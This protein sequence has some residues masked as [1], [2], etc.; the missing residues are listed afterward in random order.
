M[1]KDKSRFTNKD[2]GTTIR[3][4]PMSV[5]GNIRE[6]NIYLPLAVHKGKVVSIDE[7][8][9]QFCQVFNEKS[10]SLVSVYAMQVV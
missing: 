1:I 3:Y 9:K 10:K 4:H 6:K 8:D 7:D 5:Y 2:I